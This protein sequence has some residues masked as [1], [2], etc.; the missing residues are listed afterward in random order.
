[1]NLPNYLRTSRED[2]KMAKLVYKESRLN[3]HNHNQ[4]RM[5]FID[6]ILKAQLPKM[7]LKISLL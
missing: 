3:R 5:S 6:R 7:D 2:V 4:Q 1:M